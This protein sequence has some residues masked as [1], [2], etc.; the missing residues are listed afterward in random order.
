MAAVA[1]RAAVMSYFAGR[2]VRKTEN[3]R[4]WGRL[5]WTASAGADVTAD[6]AV[7]AV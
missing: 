3:S 4:N 2:R 5:W 6:C 7:G 1:A